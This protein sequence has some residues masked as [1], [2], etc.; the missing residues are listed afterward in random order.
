MKINSNQNQTK[1]QNL[2]KTQPMMFDMRE[3]GN[4]SDKV[5][6]K[7]PFSSKNLQRKM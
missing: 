3:N 1:N 4:L 2:K 6:F 5:L 7:L